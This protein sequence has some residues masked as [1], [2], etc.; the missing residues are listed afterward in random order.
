ME[1]ARVDRAVF[2]NYGEALVGGSYGAVTGGVYI[3][4]LSSGNVFNLILTANCTFTLSGAPASGTTASCTVI[5]QQ[6]ST[7]SRTASWPPN[8][9]WS[10]N[11]P[12][13]LST[14]GSRADILS[15]VTNDGGATWLGFVAQQD[16]YAQ[17]VQ[18]TKLFT[19]GLGTSGQ[20]GLGN[21]V[22]TR[23]VPSPVMPDE[24][25]WSSVSAGWSHTAAVKTDGTLWAWGLGT[26]GQVGDN[27]AT[28]RSSPVQVGALT[29]WSSV[30]AGGDHTTAVKT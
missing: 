15:F 8:V 5:L 19:W 22:N 26:S 18:N 25:T 21:N 2:K 24:T 27:T 10:L 6:D 13:T 11:A 7:G 29:T 9:L 20:L 30:S 3:I 14:S 12:P 28:T 16:I 17:S 4:D 23:L 1:G